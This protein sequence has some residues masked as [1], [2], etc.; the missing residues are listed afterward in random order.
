MLR[1]GELDAIRRPFRQRMTA[2]AV[3]WRKTET[4]DSAGGFVDTYEAVASYPCNFSQYPITPTER[5]STTQVQTFVAW[6]FVFPAGSDI[7]S[8]D[9][10]TVGTRRFEVTQAGAGLLEI[11]VQ[12]I[13]QEIT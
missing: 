3:V 12:A 7:R 13:C 2:T 6:R 10:L 4:S 5:E 1:P 11:Q 8:T 9:R